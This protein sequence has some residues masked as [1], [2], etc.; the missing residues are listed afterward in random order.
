MLGHLVFGRYG[1][2]LESSLLVRRDPGWMVRLFLKLIGQR[3]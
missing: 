3:H 2:W 1:D